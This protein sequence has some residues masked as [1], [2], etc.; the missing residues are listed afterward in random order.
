MS[1]KYEDG[2]WLVPGIDLHIHLL[3]VKDGRCSIT[4][5]EGEL[6]A[7]SPLDLLPW[8]PIRRVADLDGR[9]VVDEGVVEAIVEDLKR[10]GVYCRSVPSKTRELATSVLKRHLSPSREQGEASEAENKR[11]REALEG[12]LPLV[13]ADRDSLVES[14]SMLDQH[15][16]PIPGTLDEDVQGWVDDYDRA[17][18]TARAALSQTEDRT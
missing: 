1:K 17:I 8:P 12:L 7:P 5:I 4:L 6:Q 2:I 10:E 16:K 15:R 13:Q 18:N 14:A 3:F 9:P 11:L